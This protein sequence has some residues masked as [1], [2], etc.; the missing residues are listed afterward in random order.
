MFDWMADHRELL[1]YTGAAS[2]ALFVASLLIVPPLIV[3]IRPDYFAHAVRPPSGWEQ[4]QPLVRLAILVGKNV[5]GGVL[6]IAG[7]AM[8]V[9]PGQGLLTLFVGFLLI[10]FPGK[11]RL[12]QWLVRRRYIL[13]PINWLR[14][15]RHRPPLQVATPAFR[16]PALRSNAKTRNGPC[17]PGGMS[18]GGAS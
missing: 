4:Q 10:D 13:G 9:L 12:E 17:V 6:L 14:R 8:L 1:W 5:L 15:R 18:D 11:Y 2:L 16:G 3:R 7:L